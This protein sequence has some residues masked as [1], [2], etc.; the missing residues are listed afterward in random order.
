MRSL[1]KRKN[2][3]SNKLVSEA[4]AL[5]S[6]FSFLTN[7]FVLLT[8][9]GLGLMIFSGDKDEDKIAKAKNIFCTSSEFAKDAAKSVKK[10]FFAPEDKDVTNID[11]GK[12]T[13]FL[14]EAKAVYDKSYN[15]AC[16][17]KPNY[18]KEDA[19]TK[20]KIAETM[21]NIEKTK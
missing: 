15:E 9:A 13:C 3:N 17:V 7:K 21:Q 10:C 16:N 12:M 20:E 1:F 14:S 6:L 4:F 11:S 8:S 18:N 5:Y 19:N 2:Q